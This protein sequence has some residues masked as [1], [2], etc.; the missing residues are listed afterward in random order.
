MT[1]STVVN[2]VFGKTTLLLLHLFTILTKF[3]LQLI[4]LRLLQGFSYSSLKHLIPL[5]IKSYLASWNV[6]VFVALPWIG[7]KAFFLV[8]NN[9]FNLILPVPL[10]R[11]LNVV[12]L[13]CKV[14]F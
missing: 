14:P 7:L 6:M 5:T 12:S 2:L 11:L 13:N 1:Y 8:A 3:H 9:L 10:S 4:D